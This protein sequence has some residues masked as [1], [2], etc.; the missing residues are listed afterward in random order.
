MI[1]QRPGCM[2]NAALT[3]AS[4]ETFE[5]ASSGRLPSADC[6]TGPGLLIY[7][8]FAHLAVFDSPATQPR[9]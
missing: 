8:L 7:L 4:G 6:A 9:Q 2:V 1:S 5:R 3:D